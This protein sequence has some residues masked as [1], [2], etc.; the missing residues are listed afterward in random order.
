M[1]VMNMGAASQGCHCDVP[2][3]AASGVIST[4]VLWS[5]PKAKNT[6]VSFGAANCRRFEDLTSAPFA[7]SKIALIF[8]EASSQRSEKPSTRWRC[9]FASSCSQR[10]K[11][12]CWR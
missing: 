3:K 6:C 8:C 7:R 10:C 1:L 5:V 9:S 11:P 12:A 4:V 2:C